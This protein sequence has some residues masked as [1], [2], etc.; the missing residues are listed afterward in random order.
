MMN[1]R[2]LLMAAPA[3]MAGCAAVPSAPDAEGWHAVPLP[4]KRQTQYAWASKDGRRVL[5][6][7]ADNSASMWRR[8][9]EVPPERL[10]TARFSWWVQDSL[11]GADVGAAGRSDAPAAVLFA[12][13]GDHARLAPRERLM[14]DMAETLSGERP[15]YATLMYVFGHDGAEPESVLTHPRTGRVR[16][17]VLDAGP[18]HLRRWRQHERDLVT[19]FRRAFDEPPGRLLSMAVMTDADNT[20]Q[21][22]RAWYGPIELAS[23]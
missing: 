10:G 17:I 7:Y 5:A 4:G 6:A 13:D 1:R 2:G 15:P 21:T 23:R 18:A 3:L 11:P 14:F 9:M 20:G 22:A 8:R 19:D 16:K 12:F